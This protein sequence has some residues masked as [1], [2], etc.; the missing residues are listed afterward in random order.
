MLGI[1]AFSKGIHITFV[2]LLLAKNSRRNKKNRGMFT[3]TMKHSI[4]DDSRFQTCRCIK[5]L[6]PIFCLHIILS[7]SSEFLIGAFP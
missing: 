4:N 1:E 2:I 7:V 3:I 5:H 6:R